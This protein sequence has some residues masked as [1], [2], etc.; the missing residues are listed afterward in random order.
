MK[1]M[2]CLQIKKLEY[3]HVKTFTYWKCEGSCVSLTVSAP[4]MITCGGSRVSFMTRMAT[5]PSDSGEGPL[6]SLWLWGSVTVSLVTNH[7]PQSEG[8]SV[9]HTVTPWIYRDA[10][11]LNRL[12]IEKKKFT[13]NFLPFR[14]K[15]VNLPGNKS[16][17]RIVGF[18]MFADDVVTNEWI[19]ISRSYFLRCSCSFRRSSVF[20]LFTPEPLLYDLNRKNS[21]NRR[22][23]FVL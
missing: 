3:A 22:W 13:N 16:K 6:V 23:T 20:L 15:T 2:L 4:V 1:L 14:T 5:D 9:K 21:K 17:E 8:L 10:T 18:Y 11:K 12:I 19:K 7:Q